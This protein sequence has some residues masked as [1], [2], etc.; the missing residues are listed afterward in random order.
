M[1]VQVDKLWP[2]DDTVLNCSIL[3]LLCQREKR[4]NLSNKAHNYVKRAGV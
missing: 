1:R 2:I 4:Q 3:K